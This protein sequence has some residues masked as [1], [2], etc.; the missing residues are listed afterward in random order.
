MFQTRKVSWL[1]PVRLLF[2]SETY[3]LLALTFVPSLWIKCDRMPLTLVMS[4]TIPVYNVCM[5]PS[6]AVWAALI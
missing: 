1:D 3:L 5:L 6:F 2:C 4:I